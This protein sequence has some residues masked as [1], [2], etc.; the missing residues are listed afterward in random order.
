MKLIYDTAEPSFEQEINES[1]G[2]KK[3]V[4]KG[5]FSSP[6]VKNRNGRVYPMHL[7]EREVAKYQDIIKA[8]HPNSLME[9]EHPPRTNVDMMEAVA[10][11][12]KL[13][14]ENNCVMGEAVLLDNTKA[15]QLKTLIDNGIKMAVSTR[16]VGKIGGDGMV[17]DYRLSCIDIIANL[18]QSDTQAEMYG[19]TEGVLQGKDFAVNEKGDIVEVCGKDKCIRENRET[20]NNAILDMFE[21]LFDKAVKLQE[22]SQSVVFLLSNNQYLLKLLKGELFQSFDSLIAFK[23][24][25]GQL[26]VTKDWNYS[27]STT[28][29]FKQAFNISESGKEI[30]KKI[31]SG[32]YKLVTAQQ[33][34]ELAL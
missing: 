27:A 6:G 28:K 23:D 30:Q 21:N 33:M 11:V 19:I 13:W 31:D 22:S 34:K 25:G 12:R 10:R 15:N 24:E 20:V 18:N 3:Y 29:Y 17:E 2:S 14:I 1:T 9:L 7:W 4:I 32:V 8:G 26:Y 5:V 16:G